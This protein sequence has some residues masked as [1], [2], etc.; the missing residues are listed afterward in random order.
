[1]HLHLQNARFA[2][3]NVNLHCLSDRCNYIKKIECTKFGFKIEDPPI[4]NPNVRTKD[5]SNFAN[6]NAQGKQ[7]E[8]TLQTKM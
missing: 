6:A 8:N 5:D 7:W 2:N 3:V 4:E 1:M